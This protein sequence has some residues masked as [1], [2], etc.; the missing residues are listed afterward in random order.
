MWLPNKNETA[1]LTT[2]TFREN[3]H[4]L[5]MH[6]SVIARTSEESHTDVEIDWTSCTTDRIPSTR[7][8]ETLS[9]IDPAS[10]ILAFR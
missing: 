3:Q 5:G 9:R 8:W 10:R 6:V 4:T 2:W 7:K 1:A